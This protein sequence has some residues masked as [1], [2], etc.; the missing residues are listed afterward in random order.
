[1]RKTAAPGLVHVG[2]AR[3]ESERE[4]EH[5]GAHAD[6]RRLARAPAHYEGAAVRR[7][8]YLL[9]QAGHT[10]RARALRVYAETAKHFAP[11]DPGV[12]PIVAALAGISERDSTWKLLI[13]EVVEVVYD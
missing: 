5:L 10:K 6:A 3:L 2:D 1:M 13:N 12:K 11:L 4:P 8:G 9:E 7:L